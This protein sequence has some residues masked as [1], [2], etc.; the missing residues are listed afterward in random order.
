MADHKARR[1]SL[2]TAAV[3]VAG[4]PLAAFGIANWVD[5]ATRSYAGNDFHLYWVAARVG[6][7]RGWAAIYEPAIYGHEVA[8]LSGHIEAFLSPPPLAWL[9]TPFAA[10][11]YRPAFA[12]WSAVTT[13]CFL[14]AWALS[15]EGDAWRRIAFLV[16][17][18]G[19]F[20]VTFAL[21]LGQATLL[22]IA[23]VAAGAFLLRAGRSSWAGVAFAA[24][25]FKPQVALLVPI[26]L[27]VGR[28]WRALAVMA[29]VDAALA[30]ASLVAIGPGGVH[31][32]I[33]V[34]RFWGAWE[35]VRRNTLAYQLSAWLPAQAV[36]GGAIL[37]TALALYRNRRAGGDRL[38]ALALAG[39]V[40]AAVYLNEEDLA[41]LAL[42]GWLWLR[43]PT[44]VA[45]GV[46]ATLAAAAMLL[47]N[48]AGP[49]PLLA[50]L[51]GGLVVAAWRGHGPL[52]GPVEQ[53]SGSSEMTPRP[54][55]AVRS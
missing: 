39:S 38:L 45:F 11:P 10:L 1:P 24:V 48:V 7:T 4:L 5:V 33:E 54:T 34:S 46:W 30:I 37:L 41:C 15:A 52:D 18:L 17:A 9:V 16:A 43:Q 36:V 44:G 20:P 28:Q 13:A 3:L 22:V 23:G 32:Y 25:A 29:A 51:V 53:R 14:A 35:F 31:A 6:W 26:A 8:R 55:T 2:T 47:V 19:L 12:A 21:L 42:A 49:R 50:L 27:V 40:L